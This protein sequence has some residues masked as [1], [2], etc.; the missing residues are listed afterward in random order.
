M[1]ITY[2]VFQDQF[3]TEAGKVMISV[4]NCLRNINN[5][6]NFFPKKFHENTQRV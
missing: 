3:T 2:F 5:S 6:L 1:N 4:I